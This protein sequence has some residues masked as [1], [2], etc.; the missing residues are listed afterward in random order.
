MFQIGHAGL[1]AGDAP[2]RMPQRDAAVL[3]PAARAASIAPQPGWGASCSRI[4][5]ALGRAGGGAVVARRAPTR[6]GSRAGLW[7]KRRRGSRWRHRRG[8][9]SPI[10]ATLWLLGFRLARFQP[11]RSA[12]GADGSSTASRLPRQFGAGL[13]IRAARLGAVG[14]EVQ[15]VLADLEAALA[16]DLGLPL[17]DLR[18]VELLDAAALHAHQVV[19]MRALVQLEH[20]LA[21]S[22]N[23]GA[24]AGPPAR[25][26]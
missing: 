23:D 3:V 21:R 22:R 26:A 24:P 7:P 19:V 10:S 5:V 4:V 17:L 13:A 8:R 15:R 20:R 25:T 1:D 14:V 2:R 9:R 18:V 11:P 6:S 12:R 16:R